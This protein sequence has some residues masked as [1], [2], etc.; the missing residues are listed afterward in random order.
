MKFCMKRHKMQKV[1]NGC[2]CNQKAAKHETALP[3]WARERETGNTVPGEHSEPVLKMGL[4][5]PLA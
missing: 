3:V 5:R 1:G 4:D 2:V